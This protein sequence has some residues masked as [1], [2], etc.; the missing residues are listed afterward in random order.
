MRLQGQAIGV[1]ADDL[2]GAC[3]CG[4]QFTKPTTVSARIVLNLH[5]TLPQAKSGL[6][7]WIV[8]T[9]SRHLPVAEAAKAVSHAARMLLQPETIGQFYKKIDSTLRGHVAE[10][11]LAALDTL[12]FQAAII[13][14]AYP[15]EGRRTVGGYQLLRGIPIEQ[16]EMARDPLCPITQSHLPTLLATQSKPDLV[17]YVPLST[18]MS[19][20]GPI[21]KDLQTLL[22]EQKRLIVVDSCT[23]IDLEQLALA[24]NKL[25]LEYPVLPCGSAG[26]AQALA[27]TWLDEDADESSDSNPTSGPV[28]PI[29]PLLI[30]VGSVN[31]ITQ[32]QV[33]QLLE[34]SAEYLH[35][36]T[37]LVALEV[38]ASH[39]MGLEN[40][41]P[42][43]H[44]ALAAFAQ[45]QHV[46]LSSS[47]SPQSLAQ[48]M[49]LAQ[50][51]QPERAA[52][53]PAGI[54]AQASVILGDLTRTLMKEITPHLI[55]TG[56][57][58]ATAVCQALNFE[59]LRL[60]GQMTPSIPLLVHEQDTSPPTWLITK[61]G[62]FGS[63][64][65]LLDLINRLNKMTV[66]AP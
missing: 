22:R 15:K 32:R 20:A 44:Q 33:Q 38:K 27:N 36:P 10:E 31:P 23:E 49:A 11:C 56:G 14:P 59:S 41:E 34:H 24:L 60:V 30:V 8:N 58:T 63:L 28:L 12:G 5:T 13:A 52:E 43:I 4:L 66:N 47:L 45:G 19:G 3:D 6:Q 37:Q 46:L 55:I 16:S 25:P 42:L 39:I 50:E 21:L 51:H 61:S 7:H 26:F 35:H 48:T 57:E 62:G 18:V 17:G 40:P 2:T 53:D 54:A 1:I 64:T 9:Q 29:R 65:V